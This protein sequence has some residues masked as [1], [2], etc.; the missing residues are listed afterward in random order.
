MVIYTP[1]NRNFIHR[2]SCYL[3]TEVTL[4]QKQQ[5]NLFISVY[6]IGIQRYSHFQNIWSSTIQHGKFFWFQQLHCIDSE[7]GSDEITSSYSK[8]TQLK[9]IVGAWCQHISKTKMNPKHVPRNFLNKPLYSKQTMH[10]HTQFTILGEANFP[11]K[12]LS[13]PKTP[14]VLPTFSTPPGPDVVWPSTSSPRN[15]GG[16]AATS[17]GGEAK[18]ATPKKHIDGSVRNQI[19]ILNS[20]KSSENSKGFENFFWTPF[21]NTL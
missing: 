12:P 17:L 21:F 20:S 15:C 4:E 11:F 2:I 1:W 3:Y 18:L 19:R 7:P 5:M 16:P 10:K 8:Y 6:S 14:C 9:K 13:K